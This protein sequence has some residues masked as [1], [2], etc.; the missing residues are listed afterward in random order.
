MRSPILTVSTCLLLFLLVGIASAQHCS[1]ADIDPSTGFCMVPDPSLTPGLMDGSLVCESNK[2]RPRKVS[3]KEKQ[4]ILAAYG[5]PADTG[6]EVQTSEIIFGL[7]RM[8]AN[9]APW[10]KIKSNS[11]S[12]EKFALTKQ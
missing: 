7:N 2:D 5:Y 3:K 10:R 8:R 4:D 12:G 11:C 9:L 1:N 6:W